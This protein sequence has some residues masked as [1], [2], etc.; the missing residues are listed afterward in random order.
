ASEP[1]QVG[2]S[3]NFL[4]PDIDWPCL[5]D[6]VRNNPGIRFNFWGAFNLQDGNLSSN[7]TPEAE[8]VRMELSQLNNVVIHGAVDAKTLAVNLRKM[9]CLL[10]CYD[11][12]RDQ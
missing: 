9:D 8:Q 7:N 1:I 3:G 6:I 2:I 10:I 11:I 5:M 12:A 4:R